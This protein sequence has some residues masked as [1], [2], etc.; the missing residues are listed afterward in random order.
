MLIPHN[1]FDDSVSSRKHKLLE[2]YFYFAFPF[3]TKYIGKCYHWIRLD[4]F[5]VILLIIKSYIGQINTIAVIIK[6]EPLE[7]KVIFFFQISLIL[8]NQG[9]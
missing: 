9:P 2:T 5:R 6:R 1:T 3:K 4:G 7:N 8:C